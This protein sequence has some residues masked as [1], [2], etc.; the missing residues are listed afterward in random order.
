MGMCIGARASSGTS[1]VPSRRALAL[2][3]PASVW[4]T[5]GIVRS[6]RTHRGCP[7]TDSNAR[8]TNAVI[9]KE[10]LPRL[11]G[12]YSFRLWYTPPAYPWD[13]LLP[14]NDGLLPR[15]HPKSPPRSL[16]VPKSP[17]E[18]YRWPKNGHLLKCLTDFRTGTVIP[19][20]L[21]WSLYASVT[22]LSHK[23][24]LQEMPWNSKGENGGFQRLSWP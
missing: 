18:L 9:S 23:P 24:P 22:P 11:P 8:P 5:R 21:F 16:Q 2:A 20:T 15:H 13:C 19:S 17:M 10:P 3:P 1:T 7:V 12:V 4:R 14:R 6:P